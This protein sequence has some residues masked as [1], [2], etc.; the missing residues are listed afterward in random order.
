MPEEISSKINSLLKVSLHNSNIIRIGVFVI[1]LSLYYIFL[2]PF[3][4]SKITDV[5]AGAIRGA[6]QSEVNTLTPVFD[7]HVYAGE[8]NLKAQLSNGSTSGYSKFFTID[9]RVLAM[10]K[11]LIDYNSP[12]ASSAESFIKYADK[13]GLD[14]R[15]V[16]SISGVESAFGNLIPRNSNN[17]WGWR[18][19][20]G[21]AAGWSMFSTWDDGIAE[22]T[23][24]LAQGYGVTLSPFDI[25]PVYCPPCG[26]NPA[27][28]WANGVT[29]FMNQ[30]EYYTNNL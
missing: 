25:E 13:Y 19:I 6:N 23:R 1:I 20:N 9:P 7:I 10:N 26:Q 3:V 17:A 24:G 14:W 4:E 2:S 16:A 8:Y 5:F 15:L 18:G 27:H 12:M 22:V 21:N 30:L 11:F 28:T 29:R